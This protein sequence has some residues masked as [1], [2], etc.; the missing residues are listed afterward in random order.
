[1]YHYL[2]EINLGRS[3]DVFV[4][5][6]SVMSNASQLTCMVTCPVW[7]FAL[8]ANSVT[9]STKVR[10]MAS[11]TTASEP[12]HCNLRRGQP[13]QAKPQAQQK[14]VHI[15]WDVLYIPGQIR[16]FNALNSDGYS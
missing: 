11:K 13:S 2:D 3:G 6:M 7:S 15:S 16:I 8:A 4:T 12:I 10:W 9:S 1:M 5:E 14:R